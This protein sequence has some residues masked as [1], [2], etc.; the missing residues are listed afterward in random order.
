MDGSKAYATRSLL[1]ITLFMAVLVLLVSAGLYFGLKHLALV[2]APGSDAVIVIPGFNAEIMIQSLSDLVRSLNL[3]LNNFFVWLLPGVALAILICALILWM[4][5]KWTIS[6]LFLN[7]TTSPPVPAEPETG[8]SEKEKKKDYADQKMEQ[9]RKRRLFLHFLSVLQRE[10]R[11]L[12][13]FGEELDLYDDEQ[14]GAAVRSIQGDCKKA[15]EK[16]LAP[17]PVIDQEEGEMVDIAPG[18]DPDAV[19]LIGNVSGEP[20]FRGVLRHQGWKAGKK[21]VPKLSDVLDS[22]IITPAEVE[23]E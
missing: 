7:L 17:A 8:Q 16:Y 15:M 18:F 11:L 12:D 21:D 22:S 23:I 1:V 2:L 19:K 14:I 20:P 4:V 9:E 10:G 5:M 6:S 13:F 3:L